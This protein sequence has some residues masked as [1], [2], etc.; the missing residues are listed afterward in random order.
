[1]AGGGREKT[2]LFKTH[3]QLKEG[4]YELQSAYSNGECS[5]QL[6]PGTCGFLTSNFSKLIPYPADHLLTNKHTSSYA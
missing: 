5:K 4:K 1:M 6:F 3:L 2:R